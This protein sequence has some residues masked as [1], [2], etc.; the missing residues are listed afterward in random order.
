MMATLNAAIGA[1][2]LPPLQHQQFYPAAEAAHAE[3]VADR[4]L[5]DRTLKRVQLH[6]GIDEK[7]P[8]LGGRDLDLQ[9]LYV[10]VTNLGGCEQVIANKQWRVG[11]GEPP[12]SGREQGK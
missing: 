3:V 11:C 8:R 4:S 7:A 2:P 12:R 10:N 6:F 9:Q 1:S 5:F